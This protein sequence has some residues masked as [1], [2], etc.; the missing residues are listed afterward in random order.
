MSKSSSA[1]GIPE[2]SKKSGTQFRHRIGEAG[3]VRDLFAGFEQVEAF[4]PPS[5]ADSGINHV[6]ESIVE[7]FEISSATAGAHER[8][9]LEALL[10]MLSRR[11]INEPQALR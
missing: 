4:F 11:R 1:V 7:E 6:F 10:G 3:Q 2:L 5:T 8:A 9:R